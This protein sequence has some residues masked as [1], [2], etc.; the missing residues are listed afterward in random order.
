MKHPVNSVCVLGIVNAFGA[1]GSLTRCTG[2]KAR[3]VKSLVFR[4]CGGSN[5]VSIG[6]CR[7]MKGCRP[8][9]AFK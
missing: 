6:S 9:F 8:S 3:S 2:G 7:L 5:A 4:S 1:R